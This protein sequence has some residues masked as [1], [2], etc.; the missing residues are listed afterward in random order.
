MRRG[1]EGPGDYATV[2]IMV[3]A[4]NVVARRQLNITVSV[5]PV[6]HRRA[7]R[8]YFY[9]HRSAVERMVSRRARQS[10][11]ALRIIFVGQ[12]L[13]VSRIECHVSP[14]SSCRIT[15]QPLLRMKNVDHDAIV[16]AT[17]RVT[18]YGDCR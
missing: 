7:L 14:A 17:L 3:L 6:Y 11:E 13:T 9:R 1:G 5:E 4:D 2:P 15:Q 8:L 12:Q 10:P 18:E 16:K